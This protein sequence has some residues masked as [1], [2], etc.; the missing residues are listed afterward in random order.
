M[1]KSPN[2]RFRESLTEI[3][4][5]VT[6]MRQLRTGS[7]VEQE[8]VSIVLQISTM[9]MPEQHD[10][11]VL[12]PGCLLQGVERR[13]ILYIIQMSVD[14][15]NLMPGDNAWIQIDLPGVS[16]KSVVTI[17]CDHLVKGQKI[18]FQTAN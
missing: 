4:D 3:Q 13:F 8:Q 17:E 16:E 7:R 12:L 14:C 2:R 6:G 18:Q 10:I 11:R 15:Q 1:L 9:R 5:A